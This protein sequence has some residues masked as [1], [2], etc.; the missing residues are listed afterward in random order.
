MSHCPIQPTAKECSVL[1]DFITYYSVYYSVL[2]CTE[3]CC[4]TLTSMFPLFFLPY[5]MILKRGELKTYACLHIH[6]ATLPSCCTLITSFLSSFL[7][8][9][10]PCH[11]IISDSLELITSMT[12]SN[13]T[14]YQNIMRCRM[15][16]NIRHERGREVDPLQ[17]PRPCTE[18]AC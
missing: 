16:N 6:R 15:V 3:S 18:R 4:V 14:Y 2:Q 12:Y 5:F 1:H 17:G 13:I 10:L 11:V 9:Y 7:P 8:S